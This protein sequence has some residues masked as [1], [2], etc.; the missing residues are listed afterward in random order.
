MI[1]ARII[2][3]T[4][5]RR[6]SRIVRF[7]TDYTTYLYYGVMWAFLLLGTMD[8]KITYRPRY[9]FFVI[10]SLIIMAA[11]C[12]CYEYSMDYVCPNGFFKRI[13]VFDC[14]CLLNSFL[15][16]IFGAMI[17]DYA[18]LMDCLHITARIAMFGVILTDILTILV[19]KNKRYDDMSYAYCVCLLTCTELFWFLENPNA[20]DGIMSGVGILSTLLCGTRGPVICILILFTFWAFL[21]QKQVKF[22][23]I[24]VVV[25][26][27]IVLLFYTG[28]LANAAQSLSE[29]LTD[30]DLPSFRILD[31]LQ[32]GEISDDSGRGD[33]YIAIREGIDQRIMLGYGIGGD[34]ILTDHAYAHSII[35]EF[36]CHFGLLFGL[37]F[38]GAI[39]YY[40]IRGIFDKDRNLRA[41]SVI[42]FSGTVSRLIFSSSYILSPELFLLI[43]MILNRPYPLAM[44]IGKAPAIAE[45]SNE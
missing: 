37:L 3:L 16:I 44:P 11:S 35:L 12:L 43:G 34:R 26:L 20:F 4:L 40:L 18:Y 36:I 39:V 29:W 2:Y 31:M 8:V 21:Y 6:L 25:F 5:M 15:F 9:I 28:I 45:N 22:R 1:L 13:L 32:I 7:P 14:T 27:F 30:H 24:A 17:L 38:L 42:L 41:L 33:I 19:L 10:V 23:V